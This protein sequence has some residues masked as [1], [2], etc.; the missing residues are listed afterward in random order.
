MRKAAEHVNT[1]RPF[2]GASQLRVIADGCRGE[3]REFFF[4]ILA[5]FAER[6]STMPKPYEQDGKGDDAI[7]YLHYFKGACDFHITERD[8]SEEQHQAFGLA[9]LG[10]GAELG[11]V[12]I[13]ELIASGVELDLHWE[14]RPIGQVQAGNAFVAAYG[15]TKA[16]T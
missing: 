14:P 11:Y 1:L 6:V 13:A 3:E 7:V 5:E 12:C 10:Y 9:N 15:L 2:I 8:S 16:T 4:N